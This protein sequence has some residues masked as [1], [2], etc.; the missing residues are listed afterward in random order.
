MNN[1]NFKNITEN[2]LDTF[3]KAGEVAKKISNKGMKITIKA[4]KSPVTNG[5]LEVD[6]ILRSKIK[7]R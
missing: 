4:D 2:L 3:L 1:L 5:D 7:E 6:L